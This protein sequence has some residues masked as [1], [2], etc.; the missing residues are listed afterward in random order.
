MLV[1]WEWGEFQD[2]ANNPIWWLV[3]LRAILVF[4]VVFLILR[5]ALVEWLWRLLFEPRRH[6]LQKRDDLV[7]ARLFLFLEHCDE[8]FRQHRAK[9]PQLGWRDALLHGS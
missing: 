1:L 4:L 7:P 8:I 3:L 5:V 2:S 9:H 6:H